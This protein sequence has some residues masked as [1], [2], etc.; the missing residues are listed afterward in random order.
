MRSVL[1]VIFIRQVSF[2]QDTGLNRETSLSRELRLEAFHLKDAFPKTGFMVKLALLCGKKALSPSRLESNPLTSNSS[3]LETG[4][5]DW[6]TLPDL[7]AVALLTVAFGSVARRG[8]T[9]VSQIWLIAWMMIALHFTALI[10][11]SLPG[12]PGTV[13]QVV[14]LNALAWAGGLFMWACVPYRNRTSSR[15]MLVTLVTTNTLYITLNTT[16]PQLSWA[17]VTA[18]ILFGT[19]PLLLALIALR[20]GF[21]HPLRWVTV[22][23]YAGLSV[24]LL[25]FQFRVPNGQDLAFNAVIFIVYIGAAAHFWFAFRRTTAGPI[26]T[27][28][29]FVAWAC[30]FLVAPLMEAYFPHI[31]VQSEVWNLP[32]YVVAVGM[33]LLL[34]E[35]QIEH[36][37]YLALHDDLTGLPN[38]RL[39]QDRLAIAVERARRTG[40]RAA[41][42][43]IDLDEFKQVNDTAG[44]HVGDLLLKRVSQLFLGRVRR[45]DTVARTGGDEFSVILE[46][47]I[48]REDAER[49]GHLLTRLLDELHDLDG[50][51][52]QI[53]ASVGV[54]MYPEDAC[55]AASLCIAADLNMYAEKGGSRRRHPRKTVA[56]A[57]DR[58]ESQPR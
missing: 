26:V 34:L 44:H 4:L 51:T 37:K 28:S 35:D 21:T 13:A 45:S 11:S 19:C 57:L 55:D 42:L 15:W 8:R 52:V 31:H 17:L 5:L 23:L 33:I 29:G 49:V 50:H 40:S 16:F 12:I 7:G 43:L 36:N 1:P 24:F 38:R 32:K 20:R 39:F 48:T 56:V 10:F 27:V 2:R 58:P 46:D 53:G 54:G 14:A 18:A 3:T 9:L 30:V 22:T 25:L 6:S 41:L 47:P